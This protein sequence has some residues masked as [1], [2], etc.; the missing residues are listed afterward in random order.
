M[1]VVGVRRRGEARA[2][3]ILKESMIGREEEEEEEEERGGEG[4]CGKKSM[5][6]SRFSTEVPR[7]RD[8]NAFTPFGRFSYINGIFEF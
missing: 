2:L 4:G 3:P 8:K 6:L 1:V 7:Q 5:G